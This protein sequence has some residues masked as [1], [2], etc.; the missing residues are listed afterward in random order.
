VRLFQLR[1]KTLPSGPLLA[2]AEALARRAEA[3]GAT[4]VVNDRADIARLAGAG[5]LHVGQTDLTPADARLVVGAGMPIGRSTHTEAQVRVALGEPVDY[6]AIGPVFGTTSKD[7]PDPIVGLDGVRMAVR[8]ASAGRSPR[9]VVA[10]GGITL[11][12]APSVIA[13]GARSVWPTCSPPAP[14][15]RAMSARSLTTNVAPAASARR[16]R[17]S[18]RSSIG[19]LAIVLARSWNRRTPASSHLSARISGSRP[20]TCSRSVSRIA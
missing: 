13:A 6:L 3:A 16:A 18:A 12:T 8:L 1:A 19:P 17:A 14:A 7:R 10:I 11:E 4:F 20:R 9:P 15:S 2:L 5:G